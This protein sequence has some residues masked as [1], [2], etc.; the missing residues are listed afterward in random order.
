MCNQPNNMAAKKKLDENFH[1]NITAIDGTLCIKGNIHELFYNDPKKT[2]ELFIQ[3]V[4]LSVYNPDD[5][6]YLPTKAFPLSPLKKNLFLKEKSGNVLDRESQQLFFT[7]FIACITKGKAR[8]IYKHITEID[9][10]DPEPNEFELQLEPYVERHTGCLEATLSET[11]CIII[12][13]TQND[14]TDRVLLRYIPFH[15]SANQDNDNNDDDDDDDNNND[16]DDSCCWIY[17][18]FKLLKNSV[19]DK[20]RNYIKKSVLSINAKEP[21]KLMT[22]RHCKTNFYDELKNE[23]NPKRAKHDYLIIDNSQY[24]IKELIEMMCWIQ[25]NQYRYCNL[26][27]ID[28]LQVF[29]TLQ[30][31]LFSKSGNKNT[32]PECEETNNDD[33]NTKNESLANSLENVYFGM[34]INHMSSKTYYDKP[35]DMIDYELVSAKA[36][37]TLICGLLTNGTFIGYQ[38][39]LGITKREKMNLFFTQFDHT[40][41]NCRDAFRNMMGNMMFPIAHYVNY[42]RCYLYHCKVVTKQTLKNMTYNSIIEKVT[43]S[44]NKS[45]TINNS[46]S[47]SG[48]NSTY[49]SNNK[50]GAAILM[51][52]V[53]NQLSDSVVGN[54]GRTKTQ[55]NPDIIHED[56]GPAYDSAVDSSL[57]ELS[58]R[59]ETFWKHDHTKS[60]SEN[61]QEML[62]KVVKNLRNFAIKKINKLQNFNDLKLVEDASKKGMQ[63][64]STYVMHESICGYGVLG[65][66]NAISCNRL[67][68]QKVIMICEHQVTEKSKSIVQTLGTNFTGTSACVDVHTEAEHTVD[69]ISTCKFPTVSTIKLPEKF[70][71][72]NSV[73]MKSRTVMVNYEEEKKI[74][75][76]TVKKDS[77]KDSIIDN[78]NHI[79]FTIESILHFCKLL[80]AK[81]SGRFFQFNFELHLSLGRSISTYLSKPKFKIIKLALTPYNWLLKSESADEFM[82][83]FVVGAILYKKGYFNNMS[84]NTKQKQFNPC[85]INWTQRIVATKIENSEDFETTRTLFSAE[86][87]QARVVIECGH[88]NW[89]KFDNPMGNNKIIRLVSNKPPNEQSYRFLTMGKGHKIANFFTFNMAVKKGMKIVYDEQQFHDFL[90]GCLKQAKIDEQLDILIERLDFFKEVCNADEDD[91]YNEYSVKRVIPD[92]DFYLWNTHIVKIVVCLLNRWNTDAIK[93]ERWYREVK[94]SETKNDNFNYLDKLMNDDNDDEDDDDMDEE[95]SV[96]LDEDDNDDDNDDDDDDDDDDDNKDDDK[97]RNKKIDKTFGQ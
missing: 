14:L 82:K 37:M 44:L 31:Q 69:N 93:S 40:A 54:I 86:L 71:L 46:S 25:S 65:Q 95:P 47:S 55:E 76:Q 87:R 57:E 72:Q 58:K 90:T 19:I 51:M 59:F 28:K 43:N 85:Q 7:P 2:R 34:F 27:G 49:S 73:L 81:L 22:E 11:D 91:Q 92:E 42:M 84:R 75:N 8:Q 1:N 35:D 53:Y 94:E 83:M 30:K 89:I 66:L 29:A 70:K 80:Y 38:R 77:K 56:F 64:V 63:S 41:D 17:K 24:I 39:F 97:D 67:Y 88:F 45:F 50:K 32:L 3:H 36:T 62:F 96:L 15:L 20:P 4:S 52:R 5:I 48:D 61:F 26:R 60:D 6:I 10:K 13:P 12:Y 9:W 78:S 16:S 21:I 18:S 74:L 33:L 79:D 23:N 68:E